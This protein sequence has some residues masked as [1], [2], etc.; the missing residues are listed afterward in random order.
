MNIYETKILIIGGGAAG[1]FASTVASFFKNENILIEKN[2]F[3]GGQPIQI[4]PNKYIYDFP[5]FTKIKSN[6]VINQL[7]NQL[8]EAKFSKYYTDCFPIEIRK[9]IKD[10]QEFFH[11]TTN[12][13]VIHCQYII[14][15]TGNGSFAPIKLTINEK[16]I[17]SQKIH[18]AVSSN[19]DL[20]KDKRIVVLGGGDAAIEWANYFVEEKITENVTIIHRRNEYR[21]RSFHIDELKKNKVKELLN[22]EIKDFDNTF[23]TIKHNES[24]NELKVDFDWI[25]VQYGQKHVQSNIE[26][27]KQIK[28][29]QTGKIIVDNLNQKTNIKN[30]YAIGDATYYPCKPNTIVTG[31]SDA[32]KVIWHI[33][34]NR[35]EW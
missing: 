11:V 20:Y 3:L 28:C 7:I 6:E 4:Y 8:N 15:A 27:L 34:K 22:Y 32:T 16:E 23:L 13:G 25:I 14:L 35:E 2:P 18:Y 24:N 33:N 12:Q 9:I 19:T 26:F 31:C 30:V 17:E 5:C 10:N 29:H 1:I 21:A